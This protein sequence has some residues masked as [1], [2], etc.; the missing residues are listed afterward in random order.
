MT[1]IAGIH[2]VTAIAS[3]PQRNLDFY[4]RHLGLRLVKLTVNFDDPGTYHFYFGDQAGS[5]GTILTF[6]PWPH[7]KRGRHGSG[8]TAATS[9][10][11]PPS[12]LDFWA[13]RLGAHAVTRS[14]RFGEQVLAFEDPD[15]MRLELVE[16]SAISSGPVWTPSGIS[17][18]HA[19]RGFHGV[20]LA[21]EGHEKTSDLLTAGLGFELL[22]QEGNRFRYRAP[23]NGPAG[24]VDVLCVPD[25]SASKLGAGIVHHVA[26]RA[27][28]DAEQG[29]WQ[30]LVGSRG[31]NVTPVLDRSYFRSIYFRE[32]G[33]ILFEIATDQPGFA[34]DESPE[35][36]G[37]SLRLPA[38]HERIR[39][40]I[41][42]VLP[43]LRLP[44]EGKA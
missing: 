21:V 6:F 34:T 10:A 42:Q 4:A 19:I 44:G 15:G 33:G 23:G 27:R 16:V 32:P 36:L 22:A 25:L 20:T 38:Q 43:K 30:R 31:L 9:F 8:A 7:A 37:T 1:A 14:T 18:D 39:D 5:P 28:N 41:L 2:H 12:S 24:I 11:V 35:T 40:R 3:D 13:S 17:A 29:H 26:F